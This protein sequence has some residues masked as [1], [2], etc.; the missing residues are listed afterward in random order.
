MRSKPIAPSPVDAQLP[1]PEVRGLVGLLIF[2]HLFCVAVA[3]ASYADNS[4][5]EE[6]LQ[7]L[8]GPY[9]GTLNF[10]LRPNVYPTG[11]FYLT[12][13]EAGDVDFSVEIE[14]TL[15]DGQTK[16]LAVPMS[17]LG[18]GEHRHYQSL[19]NAAGAMA[20]AE[21]VEPDVVRAVA[22]SVLKQWGANRGRIRVVAHRLMPIE[23]RQTGQDRDRDPFDKQYFNTVYE[24]HV[25]VG[26][27]GRVD[28]VKRAAAGEVAPVDKGS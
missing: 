15:P 7:Q 21:G 18:H 14:G 24:A 8:F 19:A 5:L 28:L 2:V 23:A 1:S 26:P 27:D 10:D 25:L 20:I 22:G 9:T 6:R 17:D 11:R 3:L 13:A 12:H 4:P 16:E